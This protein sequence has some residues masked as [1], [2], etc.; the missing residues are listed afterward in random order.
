MLPCPKNHRKK[1]LTRRAV[2]KLQELT[3]F[4]EK[5][6][7]AEF[8]EYLLFKLVFFSRYLIVFA[9]ANKFN[10]EIAR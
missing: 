10:R 9:I 3:K 2:F 8:C 5:L 7:D 1:S 4:M 6:I